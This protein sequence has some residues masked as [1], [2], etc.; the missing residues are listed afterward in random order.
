VY[1]SRDLGH[2][3]FGCIS[4]A[5][6]GPMTVPEFP[7]LF[8][9]FPLG[10]AEAPNRIVSTSHGTNMAVDGAP[11]Q[12]LIAYHAAKA[13]GGCGVVMM[14]GSAAASPLTPISSNHVNLWQETAIPGLRAAAAAVKAHGALAISQVTSMG[15][16]SAHHLDLIG[17]GPSATGSQLAP[18]L[19]HVLST[20]EIGQIVDD[21]AAACARLKDCGFD[22]CDLAFYAD[23]LPDQFWSPS[24]N[25]RTDAYGGSLEN[26]MRFSLEVLEAIRGAVGRDFVVGARVSG[27]DWLPEGLGP[28][29][30]L[31]I[32]T[33][34]DQTGMLD[35]F[36]VT[37][38]TISTVRSRGY[39]V[40][41]AY[42]DLGTFV[43]LAA[44][45]KA[46][47]RTPIIVTGRIITPAQAEEV[48]RSGAADLIGMTRALIADPDLPRK[49]REGRLDDIRVC[50]GSSEG[51]IDRLYM[52]LPIGCVQN[53]VIGR[54]REWGAL[55]AATSPKHFLVV[56][57]GPA[58]METARVAAERGHRVTLL[59]RADQLGGAIRLAARAPGWEA[60][61]GV[62]DWLSRQL[63]QL[64]V[65][66]LLEHTATVGSVLAYAPDE[67][68][69]ATGATPRRPRL[70][71]VD[72]PNV[73]TV[74]DVLAG[75]VA[76]GQRC[77]ILDETGYTP[78]PKLADALSAAG[79]QVEI[80]TRQYSLGEDMGTTVRAK[81]YER[82]LRQ[83]VTITVLTAPIAIHA[84]GVRVRHMLTDAEGEIAADTVIL[85]SGGEA[86]DSLYHAL[87]TATA[88]LDRAPGLHLIGDAFAPRTLRLAMLDGARVA[89]AL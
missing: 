75:A 60:Y 33:R 64:R 63:A 71:G 30:L 65:E 61:R 67:V 70:P 45:V 4:V 55:V 18:H 69:V 12:R 46:A 35:Y 7:L 51:C 88:G 10:H 74:A 38:G 20:V 43:S 1:H 34:L 83:G 6:G 47:V 11:S 72:S 53:P 56:G 39:N 36:T 26:R 87:G 52:G 78:G 31:E 40:P 17:R 80:V 77:V 14:F 68:V 81:L 5:I 24:I 23:Q 79:H 86:Q 27:D 50:M 8:S 54:E 59:E 44:R 16:R 42:Y 84:A 28:Q 58:G 49:A 22:G 57:G 82:L 32:I 13:A 85:S 37:G 2:T 73:A 3:W 15:R 48:L 66:V 21:Y 25:L 19:P 62:I 9:P 41:S 76:A 29:E 89:R